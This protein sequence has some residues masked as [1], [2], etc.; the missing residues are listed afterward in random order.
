MKIL[1]TLF[2]IGAMHLCNGQ[3]INF[4]DDFVIPAEII[5]ANFIPEPVTNDARLAGITQNPGL[6]RSGQFLE[7][8]YE[9]VAVNTI[10]ALHV[11]MYITKDDPDFELGIYTIAYRSPDDLQNEIR[12][13]S[14]Y[15]GSRYLHLG[16]YMVRVWGD[17]GSFETEVNT[18]ADYLSLKLGL[19]EFIPEVKEEDAIDTIEE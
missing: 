3:K 6:V 12:K 17:S 8:I 9:G 11:A 5:P 16:R 4:P 14:M 7:E 19:L 10:E 18:L 13:M 15:A 1:H 2:M